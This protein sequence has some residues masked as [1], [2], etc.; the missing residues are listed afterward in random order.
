MDGH[1]CLHLPVI[2]PGDSSVT[3]STAMPGLG[4]EKGRS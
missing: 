4:E 2:A 3:K 1:S